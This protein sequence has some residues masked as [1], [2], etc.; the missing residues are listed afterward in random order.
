MKVHKVHKVHKVKS[1]E[2]KTKSDIFSDKHLADSNSNISKFLD[3]LF[4]IAQSKSLPR[5]S[6]LEVEGLGDLGVYRINFL[7]KYLLIGISYSIIT[8]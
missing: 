5:T 1:E 8:A 7:F 2:L 6:L 4:P 3:L